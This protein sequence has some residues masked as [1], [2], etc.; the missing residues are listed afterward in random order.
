MKRFVGVGATVR[1]VV[2]CDCRFAGVG[3][4]HMPGSRLWL[5]I[6]VTGCMGGRAEPAGRAVDAWVGDVG[7][8]TASGAQR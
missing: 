2:A 1:W 7:D 6:R 3:R 5:G 8:E 4:C